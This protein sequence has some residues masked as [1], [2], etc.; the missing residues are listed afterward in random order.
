MWV[1]CQISP[2]SQGLYQGQVSLQGS[3]NMGLGSAR[4]EAA[5]WWLMA[6]PVKPSDIQ[7]SSPEA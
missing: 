2:A 7:S 6:E 5:V 3:G 4:P 1:T